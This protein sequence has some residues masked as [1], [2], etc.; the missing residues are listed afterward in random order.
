MLKYAYE[1]TSLVE[2]WRIYPRGYSVSM[3][4]SHAESK[5]ASVV[6]MSRRRI[7]KAALGLANR[8]GVE[9]LTM[10]RLA[11]ELGRQP[12]SLYNHIRNKQ[13]LI[14][15]MRSLIDEQIDTSAFAHMEWR[16][17]ME[18]WARNYL[19]V[20][21][22]HSELVIVMATTAISDPVT[23]SSYEKVVTN[24]VASGWRR[25]QAVAVMRT[26]E[27]FVLGSA[28]DLVASDT[29]LSR[30]T[31]PPE[32]VELYANLDPASST[33]WNAQAAFEL[34][35]SSL[36]DGLELAVAKG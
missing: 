4:T 17:A 1:R 27:A 10:K 29:L 28:L 22:E 25:G 34:G 30:A 35:L 19:R 8:E 7:A 5:G 18:V 32:Y 33:L 14:E 36:L 3:A 26:V 2:W 9:S 21:S 15:A 12:P 31:V 16:A 24:L 6:P 11:A 20:F 23:L 13:D